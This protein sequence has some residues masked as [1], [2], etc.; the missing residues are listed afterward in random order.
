VSEPD[1]ELVVERHRKVDVIAVAAI[2]AIVAVVYHRCLDACFL[3]DD[4]LFLGAFEGHAR[5]MP[6]WRW[7]LAPLSEFLRGQPASFFRPISV[8]S[9]YGDYCL[10]GRVA[11]G[12]HLTNLLLHLLNVSLLYALARRYQS[13][14]VIAAAGT[15]AWALVPRL[16][17]AVTWISGRMDLIATTGVLLAL[18][19][20]RTESVGR[21]WVGALL[22]LFAILSKEVGIAGFAVLAVVAAEDLRASHHGLCL[23]SWS[24][25]V[26]PLV[27]VGVGYLA[28]RIVALGAL[29]GAGPSGPKLDPSLVLA[30][31]GTLAR[32]FATPFL[33]TTS[34]TVPRHDPATI[35]LGTAAI[36][37]VFIASWL[38][39]RW[40]LQERRVVAWTLIVC[41][42]LP[43]LQLVPQPS[44]LLSDR[45]L[46][47]PLAGIALLALSSR[48]GAGPILRVGLGVGAVVIV[49]FGLQT[50]QRNG[51]YG[52][53]LRFWSLTVTR[54]DAANLNPPYQL[55]HE[56][57]QARES[58]RAATLL[59]AALGRTWLEPD[60]W[61][62]VKARQLEIEARLAAGQLDEAAAVATHLVEVQPEVADHRLLLA[63][64]QLV[65]MDVEGAEHTLNQA[66]TDLPANQLLS[67]QSSAVRETIARYRAY[68]KRTESRPPGIGGRLAYAQ[69]LRRLGRH[70]E[71]D[72]LALEILPQLVEQHAR[73]I[74][75][76]VLEYG[77]AIHARRAV[78]LFERRF[79]ADAADP[80][81][82]VVLAAR[83]RTAHEADLAWSRVQAGGRL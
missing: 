28:L 34:L 26:V 19:V 46:Y 63:R 1:H 29:I 54:T 62:C 49:A 36:A 7:C 11:T 59:A 40:V 47:L 23:A 58:A 16:T 55:A 72:A 13:R 52:N 44:S 27:V 10:H 9:L 25:K 77:T 20:W 3:W 48:V 14:P 66:L 73:L 2:L 8:L 37:G 33:T 75:D 83:Q 80:N 56:L 30:T 5:A 41:A 35:G 50:H 70:A 74:V 45:V 42:L 68:L 15:L 82:A 81:W 78:S 65:G 57:Q 67:S 51:E 61:L 21:R 18:L 43:V 31:V 32:M 53:P 17:E 64:T 38:G 22:V 71:A 69:L 60:A 76:Q 24:A 79:G 12:F 6:W 4:A 39:R